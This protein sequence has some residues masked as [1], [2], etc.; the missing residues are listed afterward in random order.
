MDNLWLKIK[1][2]T[3][4]SIFTILVA[5]L[6]LFLFK[7]GDQPVTIWYMFRY[8][9][10]RTSALTVIALAFFGGVIGTLVFRMTYRAIRQIRELRARNAA[11]KMSQDVED[12]KTKASMLQTKPEVVTDTLS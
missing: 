7:N 8:E 6:A 9:P 12:L 10:F 4:I 1:I 2:W 5:Y 11:T 3:K